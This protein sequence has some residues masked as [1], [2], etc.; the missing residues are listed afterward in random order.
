[1]NAETFK[2]YYD[3]ILV[4][5]CPQAWNVLANIEL[6]IVKVN[7]SQDRQAVCSFFCIL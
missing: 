7:M 2:E 1:M 3:E 5:V 4:E 6:L